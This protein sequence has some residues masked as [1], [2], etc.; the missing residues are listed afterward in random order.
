MSLLAARYDLINRPKPR[1]DQTR[2]KRKPVTAVLHLEYR[3][4][5]FRVIDL[6]NRN[7]ESP[8]LVLE[9][10]DIK[11]MHDVDFFDSVINRIKSYQRANGYNKVSIA[12]YK[13]YL[14]KQ[15]LN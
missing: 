13:M 14:W 9:V 15:E 6:T 2:D 4:V 1:K 7:T 8:R 3:G 5:G 12:N 10:D 11:K